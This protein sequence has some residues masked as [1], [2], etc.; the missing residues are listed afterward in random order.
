[1]DVA[2]PRL[3]RSTGSAGTGSKGPRGVPLN[4]S[5][6]DRVN[7]LPRWVLVALAAGPVVGLAVFYLW[8]FVTLMRE[9][10]G[11]DAV[12][13]TLQRSTTWDVVWFTFWQATASTLLTVVVGLAPA[14]VIARYEFRGRTLLVGV[15][16][17]LFVLPTVVMGSAFVALLPDSLERTVWAVLA[18]H[19][20]FNLAVVV[21]VIGAMW[22]HLPTD[23]ERAAAT[24]GASGWQIFRTITLPLVRPAIVAAATVVFV[25]TFTSFGVVRILGAP[26]TRTI[27]VEVWRRATQLG[28]LGGA[29][30]LAL[31]QLAVLAVALVWSTIAQ[32]RH[33]RAL[34]L[35]AIAR[36]RRPR[37]LVE[38]RVVAVVVGCTAAVAI[39]PLAALLIRSFSTPDGWTTRAWT[40][41]GRRELRPGVRVGVDPAAAI[42][43]SLTITAWATA[44]AVVIGALASLA[45]AA[46][47]RHGRLLDSGLMLPLGTSAVTIGF[48]MLIT[49]DAAPVD[50]RA[51]WWLVPI[52][53]ALVAV[54][55]VVRTCVGVLRSV[56]PTATAAAATLGASPTRAWR[57]TV[58]PY[59]WRP[60]AAGAALAAAISLG[61]FGATSFLSRS[62]NETLPIAIE[63][64][65]GRTGTIL[66]AQGFVL[67]TLLALLTIALVVG[68]EHLQ[69]P[70]P[71]STPS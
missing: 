40:D 51:S 21:R 8:P 46:A 65:V 11:A 67:A 58:I 19:V 17:A 35:Q 22:E 28:D 57:W 53:H 62:G 24:L 12:T 10:L 15:L 55:F 39:A 2:R 50:W 66:Q 59:L 5:P 32:R 6:K 54:P 34:A 37:T 3:T 18:A 29:A 7:R 64:L 52:G 43:S 70:R 1:M 69:R 31:L 20:A 16:T 47:G 56:D 23:M 45:I 48:G 30:V 68:V 71:P 4:P 36:R 63:Q 9:A 33:T 60:L 38:R 25:F 42:T 44:I 49:F 13:D 14:W 27:E 61:E 41:L 26:G